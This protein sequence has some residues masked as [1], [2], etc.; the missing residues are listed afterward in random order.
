MGGTCNTVGPGV[1]VAEVASTV[2]GEGCVVEEGDV[3]VAATGQTATR[4][5][6][7]TPHHQDQADGGDPERYAAPGL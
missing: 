4:N 6:P 1:L 7:E 3:A 5:C 2:D